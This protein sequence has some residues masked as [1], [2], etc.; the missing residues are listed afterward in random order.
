MRGCDN[1][2]RAGCVP[3]TCKLLN[4]VSVYNRVQ[5]ETIEKEFNN[6][7]LSSELNTI[8]K[9]SSHLATMIFHTFN[10]S[11]IFGSKTVIGRFE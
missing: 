3:M 2:E 1:E 10:Q 4:Y 6:Y 8:S 9:T 5:E 7:A 11:H